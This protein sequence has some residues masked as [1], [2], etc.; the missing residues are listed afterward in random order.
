MY[1]LFHETL[2]F[3]LSS[4]SHIRKNPDPDL[5]LHNS[6]RIPSTNI[7]ESNHN[8][9]QIKSRASSPRITFI[10]SLGFSKSRRML[11]HSYHI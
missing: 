4:S 10:I 2:S 3:S 5:D 7:R 6:L 9:G 11:G 1:Y 8:A